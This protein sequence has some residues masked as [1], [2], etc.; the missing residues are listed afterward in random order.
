MNNYRNLENK[1][2]N[3]IQ[4]HINNALPNL[5]N[6]FCRY[7]PSTEF[8]DGKMS[9][10]LVFN[11]NFTISI[12]IRK[13]K[14]LKYLDLTIRSKSLKG[15]ETEL[16]KINKGMAQIYFY[17]YMDELQS[18]LIKIRIV[19]VDAIRI[20]INKNK[21]EH[22]INEDGTEFFTFKFTDIKENNGDIYKYDL[23]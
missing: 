1:F 16:D 17:A 10:D 12:R 19:N 9:F 3:E 8:E 23:I 11:L 2:S 4:K 6:K 7:R 18:K 5:A 21:Y 22:K 15:Y 14:Y 13:N 20:L